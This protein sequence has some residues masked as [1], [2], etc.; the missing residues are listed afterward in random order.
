M[1]Q[2][3]VALIPTLSFWRYQDRHDRISAADALEESAV[4]QLRSWVG[5]G[6][7]VLYGTDLGWVTIYDPTGEYAVGEG[8][9]VP[10]DSRRADHRARGALRGFQKARRIAPGLV[11]NL[12]VIRATLPRTSGPSQ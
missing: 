8:D 1:K 6:G 2:A 7:I 10:S 9:D 5:A 11:A 12:A 3:R 4:R